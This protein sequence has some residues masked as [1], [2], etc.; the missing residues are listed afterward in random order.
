MKIIIQNKLITNK[1][2]KKNGF[3][4]PDSII[5]TNLNEINNFF[6]EKGQTDFFSKR[7]NGFLSGK[8]KEGIYFQHEGAVVKLDKISKFSDEIFPSVSQECI[9]SIIELRCLYVDR[10]IFCVSKLLKSN[11]AELPFELPIQIKVKI[12]QMMTDLDLNFGSLDFLIDRFNN[13]YFLEVNPHGQF[14]LIE[15]LGDKNVYEKIFKYIYEKEK[16]F[17]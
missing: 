12:S 4:I 7:I 15:V 16:F 11:R 3:L 1:K 9:D 8:T 14:D 13:Y 2:K 5:S 6:I 17:T 10:E